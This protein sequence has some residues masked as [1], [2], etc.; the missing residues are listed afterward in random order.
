MTFC[1]CLH[2][3]DNDGISMQFRCIALRVW[4]KKDN[5]LNTRSDDLLR[6]EVTR[7]GRAI[8]RRVLN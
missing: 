2:R 4:F 8:K 6:A 3:I 5:L 7:K 1:R